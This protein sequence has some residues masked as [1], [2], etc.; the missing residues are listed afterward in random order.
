MMFIF[1]RLAPVP[2][3][4]QQRWQTIIIIIIRVLITLGNCVRMHC[5]LVLDKSK[6]SQSDNHTPHSSA[7]VVHLMYIC[8]TAARAWYNLCST[9]HHTSMHCMDTY[10]F[11]E[12]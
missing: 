3:S 5:L 10:I 2:G 11:N 1:S 7:D 9:E 12:S 6:K 8:G 4:V